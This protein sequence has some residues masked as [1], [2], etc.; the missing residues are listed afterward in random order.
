MVFKLFVSEK[1]L[2]MNFLTMFM[3][4]ILSA[5]VSTL[6]IFF[7][8][9]DLQL[10]LSSPIRA[11]TVFTW[12]GLEVGFGSAVMVIFFSLPLLFAYSYYFA[13]GIGDI[14]A[15]VLVFLLYIVCGVGSV[16]G[17]VRTA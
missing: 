5:L 1:I 7:L 6:N 12:K 8:S 3:M 11:R 4:L 9:R 17:S 15:I 10:L 14:A 13:P 2:T 16:G